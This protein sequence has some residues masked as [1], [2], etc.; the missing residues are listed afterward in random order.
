MKS[1]QL[2]CTENGNEATSRSEKS[3]QQTYKTKHGHA[4]R[5]KSMS[6]HPTSEHYSALESSKSL[7]QNIEHADAGILS[8]IEHV[9]ESWSGCWGHALMVCVCV[10]AVN[11]N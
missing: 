7:K 11:Q 3:I 2:A 10:A 1:V 4:L 5:S 9:R 6:I 8:E